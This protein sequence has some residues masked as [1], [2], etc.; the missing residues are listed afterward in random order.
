MLTTKNLLR[1]SIL[2]AIG[3]ILMLFEFPLLPSANFLKLNFC[4]VPALFASFAIGP[5]AGFL[6]VVIENALH[7]FQSFSGGVGELANVLISGP[8]VLAA[9]F[10]YKKLHTKKGAFLSLLIGSVVMLVAALLANRFI[11]LP[12]YSTMMPIPKSSYGTLLLFAILPF[13]AI[14]AVI[15]TVLTMLLYNPLSPLLKQ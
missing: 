5:V 2:G 6:V 12:F 13:N 7:L 14:K 9:G 15:I 8:F 3:F 1:I 11:N 4:D 10:V